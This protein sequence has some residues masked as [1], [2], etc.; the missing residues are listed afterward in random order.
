MK[1][2]NRNGTIFIMIL[3]LTIIGYSLI[4]IY[5]RGIKSD[6]SSGSTIYEN[7]RRKQPVNNIVAIKS[8]KPAC[9][10]YK[11]VT[12]CE[13][14]GCS[15]RNNKCVNPCSIYKNSGACDNAGCSWD[16]ENNKCINPCSSYTSSETCTSASC[17][18]SDD[19][20][21]NLCSSYTSSNTCE[22]AGCS[23]DNDKCVTPCSSYT[24][25]ST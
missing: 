23:W 19:K 5:T 6:I 15:W 8:D 11:T 16:K 4:H 25:S 10:T 7:N 22:T 17:R 9:S 24:T 20:C 14:A 18:W 1:N 13:N 3:I 12:T 21:S 2:N